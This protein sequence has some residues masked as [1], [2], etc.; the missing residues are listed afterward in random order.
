MEEYKI[1]SDKLSK[2]TITKEEKEKLF[3][4]AF[5]EQFMKSNNKGKKVTYKTVENEFINTKQ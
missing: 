4:L 3:V 1:L 2:G 5:G